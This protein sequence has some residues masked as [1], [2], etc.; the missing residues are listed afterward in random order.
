MGMFDQQNSKTAKAPSVEEI[1]AIE[2]ALSNRP[3]FSIRS[4]ITLTFL[5]A[6]LFSFIIGIASMIYISM[7]NSK[8]TFFD[9]TTRFAFTVEQARRYEKNFFLY[10]AKT[11]LFDALSNIKIAV[12]ILESTTNEMRSLV[13]YDTLR[14][15][16]NN[17]NQY[18]KLLK[19]IIT[20]PNQTSDTTNTENPDIESQLRIYGH[21]IFTSS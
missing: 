1:L 3:L 7:M 19:Q 20:H 10:H 18:E 13:N 21:Q 17:L 2:K 6:F 11:D 14:D 16:K 9:N 15:L 5:V 4:R 12:S 8:Q